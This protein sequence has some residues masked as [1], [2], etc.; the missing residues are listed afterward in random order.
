MNLSS[1]KVNW[2]NSGLK[3]NIIAAYRDLVEGGKPQLFFAVKAKIFK[4]QIQ[5][6]F[7]YN[8]LHADN[9]KLKRDKSQLIWIPRSD[10]NQIRFRTNH[11]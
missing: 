10:L 6:Q 1:I 9:S 2:K 4:N 8:V 11:V 7:D 3:K 5:Q